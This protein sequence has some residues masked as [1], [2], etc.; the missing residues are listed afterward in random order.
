MNHNHRHEK[1]ASEQRLK[2]LLRED[3]GDDSEQ[4]F[5]VVQ[6][7]QQWNAPEVASGKT[8]QLIDLLANEL[9]APHESYRHTLWDSRPVLLLRSQV[10]VVQREL[11]IASA[12]VMGLGILVTLALMSTDTFDG[13]VPFVLLAP[14]VT[15]VGIA[16]VYGPLNDPALELELATPISPQL[17]AL[18]RVTL[19]FGF[20]LVLGLVGSLVLAMFGSGLSLLPLVSSWLAPMAFLSAL[21]FLLSVLFFDPMLSSL[22]SVLLWILMGMR[23]HLNID[24]YPFLRL[25]PNLLTSDTRPVIWLGAVLMMCAALWL[26]GKEG[27]WLSA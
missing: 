2:A 14:V 27:R 25:L 15:A 21:A 24:V 10:R 17:I 23:Q 8:A 11:W 13:F 5:P 12:L 16:C 6:Q 22:F 1:Q 4:L 3:V 9:P 26:V 20:N 18:A 7:L 19:V